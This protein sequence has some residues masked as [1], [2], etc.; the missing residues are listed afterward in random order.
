MAQTRKRFSLEL[1][2]L[3]ASVGVARAF[4]SET[5]APFSLGPIADDAVLVLSELVTNAIEHGDAATV[6]V[7]VHMSPRELLLQVIDENQNS[8]SPRRDVP[9]TDT[10][11]RGLLIVERLASRWG[12]IRLDGHQVVWAEFDLATST[13]EWAS[14]DGQVTAVSHGSPT[15]P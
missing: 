6:R 13:G 3:P 1:A 10:Q 14:P 8:P 12:R 15:R 2:A 11:G 5:V 7:G 9:A 4:L